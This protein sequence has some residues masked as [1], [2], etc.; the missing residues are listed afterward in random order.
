MAH[1]NL[2][3][4]DYIVVITGTTENNPERSDAKINVKSIQL[5][6]EI[7]EENLVKSLKIEMTPIEV[8]AGKYQT[9]QHIIEQFPGSC[10]VIF[11]FNDV[12]EQMSVAMV[13]K[14]GV[15]FGLEV[16]KML[17]DMDIYYQP[18]I[19]EKWQ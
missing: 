11:N 14:Y 6:S 19:D 9:I 13:S 4:K 2:F 10:S 16:E 15:K 8:S 18:I 1:K 5:A 7:N 3:S 17:E 12:E